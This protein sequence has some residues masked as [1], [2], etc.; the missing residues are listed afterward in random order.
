MLQGTRYSVNSKQE[1]IQNNFTPAVKKLINNNQMK[2][3][4]SS[5]NEVEMF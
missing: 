2:G 5:T 4:I 3:Q 1:E